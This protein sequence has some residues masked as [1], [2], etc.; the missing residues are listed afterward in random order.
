MK[1]KE[2]MKIEFCDLSNGGMETEGTIAC[3]DGGDLTVMLADGAEK[4]VFVDEVLQVIDKK[5]V[6]IQ[7][8][9]PPKT[10][11]ELRK[12]AQQSNRLAFKAMLGRKMSDEQKA[13]ALVQ[14][15][16]HADQ[17]AALLMEALNALPDG[18]LQKVLDSDQ[19][20]YKVQE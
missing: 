18:A 4:S 14:A 11:R 19:S 12:A 16:F 5:P 9:V 10:V 2:G 1:Y 3:V 17:A 8:K 7:T 15:S 20:P 6:P 13:L